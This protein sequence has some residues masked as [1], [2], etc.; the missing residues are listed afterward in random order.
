MKF[1]KQLTSFSLA[2]LIGMS[3]SMSAQAKETFDIMVMYTDEAISNA[4]S[5]ENLET[6]SN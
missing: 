6:A 3:G 5:L 1:G 2:A 4:G